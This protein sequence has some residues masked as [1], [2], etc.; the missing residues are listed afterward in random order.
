MRLDRA[1][2]DGEAKPAAARPSRHE[3]IEQPLPDLGRDARAVV[4]HLQP[5]RVLEI[6][7]VRVVL[8]LH[9]ARP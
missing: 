7:A 2:N 8:A 3:R 6:G 1:L 4:A 5:H 9:R